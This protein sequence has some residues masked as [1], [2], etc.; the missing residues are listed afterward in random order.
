MSGAAAKIARALAVNGRP[1]VLKRR[2]GTTTTTTDVTVNGVA[3]NYAPET[4][5]GD[6]L[7]GDAKVTISNAEI[8]A[9]SWPGPPSRGDMIAIDSRTWSVRGVETKYLGSVV[10]AHV[11]HVRGGG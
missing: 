9:A 8:A 7:Q 3:Q 4:L 10:L 2:T 11:L 5:V 6:I 1:M